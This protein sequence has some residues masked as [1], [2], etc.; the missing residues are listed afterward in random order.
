[1]EMAAELGPGDDLA[2]RLRRLRERVMVTLAH[3]DLNGLA[4]LD[5]VFETM[6]ALAD[7]TI[8]AAT[9]QAQ[10]TLAEVHGM[11][12]G[13]GLVVAA[14][15]KLGGRELNVSS[16][17]DL[18]FLYAED[19]ETTG[20]R[21][22]AHQ[23]FFVRAGR[24]VIALLSELTGE[25]QVFRVDMRLRPFGDSGPLVTPLNGLE[26]YFIAHARPW[27]R[28]AWMKAR[29]VAGSDEG[30]AE[31]VRPFVYRRY[32]D[33]G[34]L[35]SLRDM[36]GRIADAAVQRRKSDDVKVGNG[37]IRELE[38]TVQLFQMV[39]GGREAAL[40]TTSTREALRVEGNLGLMEAERVTRLAQA[41]A[42]L[43][44]LEHRL[45]YY[46]DQQTQA[47][48]RTPG[49]Q[50]IIA[51]GMDFPDYASLLA[52]LDEHRAQVQSA[53]NALFEQAPASRPT[54]RL[55]ALLS[56]PQSAP[57]PEVLAE[58]LKE[59]GIAQSEPV[60]KRLIDY[61]RSRR[62]RSIS[63]ASRAKVEKLF[64]EVVAAAAAQGGSEIVALRL[65]DLIEAIDGR[66]SYFSLLLEFPQV[67]T[68]AA[69]LMARSAWAARLLA[70][71]PILLDELTRV[72]TSNAIDWT[73]ERRALRIDCAECDDD[74]ERL[75]DQLRHYKQRQVLRL[76]IADIEGALPVMA[77]SDEL[78]ALA[79]I[80]LDA[81][82]AAATRSVGVAADGLCVVGYGKLGG[83]ELGYGSD[84]DIIFV[85][86]DQMAGN[87]EQFARVAQRVNNW[88]TTL[89]AA[90][91]LYDIDLR[92]RPDGIKGLMVSSVSSFRDYQMK[93]AWTWE[94]QA[95]T[96]ARACA[97]DPVAGAQF[98]EVRDQILSQPRER[99]KLFEEIVAMRVKMRAQ[100]KADAQDIKHIEGGIIDLEFCVQALVLADGPAHRELRENKGN[101]TLLK[102][103]G[104]LGLIDAGIAEAA[105]NA[106]LEMRHRSHLGALNDEENVT[107]AAE[108]LAPERA[109]VKA[110]WRAVF[111]G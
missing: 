40:R 12:A 25:G 51:E 87:A 64:P 6:T 111:A 73:Q 30:F 17:V 49:H 80:I 95:L 38:F 14:L 65:I 54:S 67:L 88:M 23:E 74:V 68:R 58:Q 13:G 100:H 48:P 103:A 3:R 62:Y 72:A 59:A 4:G 92:L 39:R 24:S 71:H 78:A 63:A 11:P 19:G 45:Q 1:A 60:A 34:M 89:T 105:A 96:R 29:V 36:H 18:V 79:D 5:E 82:L 46:D 76:T 52:A 97:G 56:D 83:K 69:K 84:L 55:G 57:E 108:D 10:R 61:T 101:H 42:F 107:L 35:E 9:A 31:R 33:F 110:L 2:S 99:V 66:D 20:P 91:V 28:Y 47:L 94:H 102:R 8:A 15:G 85:Y 16:D 106:Y 90:G 26:D 70:R 75:L 37:G 41:Y 98:E 44:K 109:A 81:T 7:T 86:E 22:I 50:A 53:F 21:P 93:R 43:R 27:E 77:L 32:L 104:K